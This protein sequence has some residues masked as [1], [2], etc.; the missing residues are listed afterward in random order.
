MHDLVALA[1]ERDHLERHLRRILQIAID[2]DHGVAA[3]EVESSRD[4]E[5]VAEVP[6]QE[7]ELDP[8][9]AGAQLAHHLAAAVGAAVVHEDELAV[10]VDLP[11]DGVEP[12]VQL[13]EHLLLVA[14]RH[15]E[16]DLVHGLKGKRAG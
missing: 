12:A 14:H 8:L 3:G 6:G 15:D 9:V 7:E 2:Q 11:G 4:R 13:G 5:L 10:A 1:P 16:R